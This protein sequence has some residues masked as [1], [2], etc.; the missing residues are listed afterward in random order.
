MAPTK[1]STP[2]LGTVHENHLTS[3]SFTQINV[4][5]HETSKFLFLLPFPFPSSIVSSMLTVRLQALL[6]R[7]PSYS[8]KHYVHSWCH[9]KYYS[10]KNS[11]W[12]TKSGKQ[13]QLYSNCSVTTRSS[14]CLLRSNCYSSVYRTV[15]KHHNNGPLTLKVYLIVSNGATSCVIP[16]L[17]DTPLPQVDGVKV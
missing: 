16:P 1:W 15:A 9:Q 17:W 2:T 8:P 3:H 14:S 6:G 10:Y 5:F 7:D 12:P 11:G 4:T 13:V